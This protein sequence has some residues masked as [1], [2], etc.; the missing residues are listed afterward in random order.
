MGRVVGC[1]GVNRHR[2]AMIVSGYTN[3]RLDTAD[4]E[5][6]HTHMESLS[7]WTRFKNWV[8]RSNV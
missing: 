2:K 7:L 4:Q 8:R 1:V 6:K 5:N 3:T